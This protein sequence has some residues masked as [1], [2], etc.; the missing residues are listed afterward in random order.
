MGNAPVAAANAVPVNAVMDNPTPKTL[1][2]IAFSRILSDLP[3]NTVMATASP[4]E[5]S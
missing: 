2:L 5:A 3:S 4:G 1:R